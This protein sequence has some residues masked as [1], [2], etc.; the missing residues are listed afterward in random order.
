MM[1][2]AN[3]CSYFMVFICNVHQKHMSFLCDFGSYNITQIAGALSGKDLLQQN[4][5]MITF[6]NVP[7]VT[8]FF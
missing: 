7:H 1:L 3:L 5:Y 4:S 6:F 2:I 8:L